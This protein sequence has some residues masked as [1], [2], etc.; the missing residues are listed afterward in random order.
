MY[1]RTKITYENVFVHNINHLLRV[2]HNTNIDYPKHN[3]K[4]K[5]NKKISKA[6]YSNQIPYVAAIL[7]PQVLNLTS[8]YNR[9]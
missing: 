1:C 7:D 9:N 8:P 6:K 2:A 5:I 3:K 4:D